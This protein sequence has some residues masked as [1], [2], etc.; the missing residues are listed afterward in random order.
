MSL[1]RGVTGE[2]SRHRDSH[3]YQSHRGGQKYIFRL[4]SNR[5][6]EEESVKAIGVWTGFCH[7]GRP[8]L[9]KKVELAYMGKHWGLS[10][11]EESVCYA[12][13]LPPELCTCPHLEPIEQGWR[14]GRAL[15]EPYMHYQLREKV[16]TQTNFERWGGDVAPAEWWE[17]HFLEDGHSTPY[18]TLPAERFRPH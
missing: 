3:R 12:C 7:C 18:P 10:A 9:P 15:Q 14:L 1:W 16:I 8:L 6:S 13:G 11:W 5:L 4:A 2:N 17:A